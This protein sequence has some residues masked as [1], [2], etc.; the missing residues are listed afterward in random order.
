M[1][2]HIGNE[3]SRLSLAAITSGRTGARMGEMP[4][5]T[6]VAMLC[7]PAFPHVSSPPA[8]EVC[9]HLCGVLFVAHYWREFYFIWCLSSKLVGSYLSGGSC[10]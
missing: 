7:L 9:F 10:S 2:L 8:T 1:A 5:L 3:C 4:L 6:A